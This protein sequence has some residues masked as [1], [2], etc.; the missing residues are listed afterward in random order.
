[1]EHC[2][3]CSKHWQLSVDPT[4]ERLM[5]AATAPPTHITFTA[6][7]YYVYNGTTITLTWS[8]DHAVSVNINQGIGTVANAGSTTQVGTS[9]TRTYTLT[10]DGL[11]GL[12]YSSSLT[13]SWVAPPP[14]PCPWA[15]TQ[16]ESWFC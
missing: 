10:A 13:I 4:T 8:I 11:D 6:D 12:V 15:G 3:A 7:G 2:L 9:V 1:M 14:P 5:S 16:F